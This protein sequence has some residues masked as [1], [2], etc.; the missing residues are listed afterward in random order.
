MK[1]TGE[2]DYGGSWCCKENEHCRT[3]SILNPKVNTPFFS[4][5][6]IIVHMML[7][8]I[9]AANENVTVFRSDMDV[10]GRKRDAGKWRMVLFAGLERFL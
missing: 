10:M 2:G 9:V 8:S 4:I 6:L 7:F 1:C 3:Q 5:N